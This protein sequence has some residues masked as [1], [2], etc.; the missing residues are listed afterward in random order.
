MEQQKG[1]I[2]NGNRVTHFNADVPGPQRAQTGPTS[3]L[4]FDLSGMERLCLY[5][6]YRPHNTGVN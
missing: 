1:V 3:Y 6:R 5:L 2:A 4:N